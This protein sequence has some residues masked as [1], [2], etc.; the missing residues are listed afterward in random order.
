MVMSP[1]K[2]SRLSSCSC[3]KTLWTSLVVNLS[4]LCS[5]TLLIIVVTVKPNVACHVSFTCCIVCDFYK[6]L[7]MQKKNKLWLQKQH[8]SVWLHMEHTYKEH[9]TLTVGYQQCCHLHDSIDLFISQPTKRRW[10]WNA[11]AS[12][13]CCGQH[14]EGSCCWRW[15]SNHSSHMVGPSVNLFASFHNNLQ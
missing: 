11:Y 3:A 15:A 5:K 8:S 12:G 6:Y 4:G 2:N 10:G 9:S 14:Q 13:L 7:N 1:Y